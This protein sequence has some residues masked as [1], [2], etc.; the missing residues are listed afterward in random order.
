MS[1]KHK[2]YGHAQG[3]VDR[4]PFVWRPTSRIGCVDNVAL[5]YSDIQF[6]QKVAKHW[7]ITRERIARGLPVEEPKE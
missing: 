7:R 1:R 5:A 3:H 2:S 6:E 4:R